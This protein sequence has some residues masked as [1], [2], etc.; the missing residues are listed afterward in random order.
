MF[1]AAWCPQKIDRCLSKAVARAAE[2]TKVGHEY[3]TQWIVEYARFGVVRGPED[4]DKD[5]N[6]YDSERQLGAEHTIRS[7]RS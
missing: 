2:M 5:P 1:V 3:I 6:Y 4:S 7:W